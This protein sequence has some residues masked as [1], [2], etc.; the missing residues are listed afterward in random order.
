MK[1]VLDAS[2][3][4]EISLAG[5]AQKYLE[6]KIEEA[7]ETLAPDLF[8]AEVVNAISKAHQF[9]GVEWGQCVQALDLAANLP[10]M[11]VPHEGIYREAFALNRGRTKA[12]YNNFYVAL[13]LREDAI[14]L[15][16]DAVLKKEAKRHGIPVG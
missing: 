4:L 11:F 15:T 8:L 5:A 9:G 13:A 7:E 1:C 10:D 16:L 14:L 6:A 3:A 12:A 2:A